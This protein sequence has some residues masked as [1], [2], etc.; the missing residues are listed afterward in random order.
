MID[1]HFGRTSWD[2]LLPVEIP[3]GSPDPLESSV[4]FPK[5][6]AVC[7][8]LLSAR[9][10]IGH[11]LRRRQ[12]ASALGEGRS[13]DVA[14]SQS[15]GGKR[16]SSLTNSAREVQTDGMSVVK[17]ARRAPMSE[18]CAPTLAPA[19]RRDVAVAHSCP[20]G[21]WKQNSPKLDTHEVEISSDQ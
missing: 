5:P 6:S 4:L 3:S 16:G 11:C 19:A 13:L 8:C 7:R 1:P 10:V 20:A 17:A 14:V 18:D 15:E 2:N 9:L 21:G 12:C